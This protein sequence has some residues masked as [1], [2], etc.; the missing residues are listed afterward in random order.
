[1]GRDDSTLTD[2]QYQIERLRHTMREM[3]NRMKKV[4]DGLIPPEN[5]SKL[6]N[7]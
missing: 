2:E 5:V 1:M 3:F 6:F 7:L 4:V